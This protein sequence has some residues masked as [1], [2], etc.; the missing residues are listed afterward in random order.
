[1]NT[2]VELSQE[3]GEVAL[4]TSIKDSWELTEI[5]VDHIDSATEKAMQFNGVWLPK[6][7]IYGLI[8]GECFTGDES[9]KAKTV[10]SIVIPSWLAYRERL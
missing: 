4:G 9:I 7:M 6:S 3:Y 5:D 2:Q 10:K 8:W 1:M